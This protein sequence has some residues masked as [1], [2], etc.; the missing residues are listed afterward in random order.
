[1][2]RIGCWPDVRSPRPRF[3]ATRTPDAATGPNISAT[4]LANLS[5]FLHDLSRQSGGESIKN[6]HPQPKSQRKSLHF[7]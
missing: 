5:D 3:A 6:H 1:M 4:N 2:F 7:Q